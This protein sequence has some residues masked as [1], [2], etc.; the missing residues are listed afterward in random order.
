MD[1]NWLIDVG[2]SPAPRSMTQSS[3]HFTSLFFLIPI[4]VIWIFYMHESTLLEEEGVWLLINC[5]GA[6][7]D[8]GYYS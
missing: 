3:H 8:S 6:P 2:L 4:L 7:F 5:G 1:G